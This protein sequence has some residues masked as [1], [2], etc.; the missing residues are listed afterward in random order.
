MG[1]VKAAWYRR[2]CTGGTATSGSVGGRRMRAWT[3]TSAPAA[4][5]RARLPR[6]VLGQSADEAG[7]QGLLNSAIWPLF[8]F[9]Q[10]TRFNEEEWEAYRRVN[11]RFCEAVL[12]EARPAT[13]CG[14]RTTTSC[15]FRR[16]CSRRCRMRPSGSSA[17][18]DFDV[19][20]AAVARR[21]RPRGAGADRHSSAS[22]AFDRAPFPCPAASA[23]QASKH[24]RH[25]H[26]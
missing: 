14:S 26:G 1:S 3:T 8:G 11:E 10:F 15:C 20:H 17:S 19:P 5:R 6:S 4:V 24:E 7:T 18:F 22:H 16:C 13:R 23:W 25:A 2:A 21:D 9:P 12:A